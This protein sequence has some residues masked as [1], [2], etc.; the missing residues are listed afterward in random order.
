MPMTAPVVTIS[1]PYGTGG[2]TIGHTVAERLGVPFLDRAIPVTV[3]Q[4]LAVSI[5]DAEAHD[6]RAETRVGR[7][8]AALAA[9]GIGSPTPAPGVPAHTFRDETAQVIVTAAQTTGCVVLGRAGVMV[10]AGDPVALHVRLN[11]ARDRRIAQAVALSTEQDD[12]ATVRKLVDDT[13]RNRKAYFRHFYNVD[14][15]DS[16]LYH[17]AIDSTV[18]DFDTCVEIITTAT[19]ARSR[20]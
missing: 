12:E 3:A 19:R 16:S 7:M 13:D 2:P 15:D 4:T 6:E 17:L 8:L 14:A 11:G 1:A 10:L 5:D 18:L 20:S 9:A